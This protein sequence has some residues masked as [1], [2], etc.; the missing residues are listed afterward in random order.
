M[1]FS[2]GLGNILLGLGFWELRIVSFDFINFF[3]FRWYF[4]FLLSKRGINKMVKS[5]KGFIIFN[6][7]SMVR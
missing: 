2:V 3:N 7:R 6:V 1:I 5:C 4:Y